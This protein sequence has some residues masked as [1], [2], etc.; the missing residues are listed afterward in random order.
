LR[1]LVF[2]IVFWGEPVRIQAVKTIFFLD[3][4]AAVFGVER[5]DV[6]G[7]RLRLDADRTFMSDIS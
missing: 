2:R 6:G 3:P 1:G 5:R 7:I 4:G